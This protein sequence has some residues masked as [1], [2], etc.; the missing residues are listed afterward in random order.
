[1]KYEGFSVDLSTESGKIKLGKIKNGNL[2]V[3]LLSKDKIV[4]KIDV[5]IAGMVARF[6]QGIHELETEARN[7][8][9]RV[10]AFSSEVST[11]LL[12]DDHQC[13]GTLKIHAPRSYQKER[14]KRLSHGKVKT[15][16]RQLL[17]IE[18]EVKGAHFRNFR[19]SPVDVLVAETP[20][21]QRVN[22]EKV[23]AAFR[24]YCAQISAFFQ[25]EGAFPEPLTVEDSASDS[26]GSKVKISVTFSVDSS[27]LESRRGLIRGHNNWFRER[28]E[29][30]QKPKQVS[31]DTSGQQGIVQ[32]PS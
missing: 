9:H 32:P 24:N 10:T 26:Y 2:P 8:G 3:T 21:F 18:S 28:G 23:D 27:V 17:R 29:L 11:T 7:E 22:F 20:N 31:Q 30:P 6:H 1:M 19:S 5:D 14:E 16:Y 15:M 25:Q 4:G 13:H 12:S